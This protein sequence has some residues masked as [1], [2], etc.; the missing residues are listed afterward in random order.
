MLEEY[1]LTPNLLILIGLLLA[2]H[3]VLAIYLCIG[4][5]KDSEEM[6]KKIQ[7]GKFNKEE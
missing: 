2:A 1:G 4:A 6:H 7:A 3:I 5:K